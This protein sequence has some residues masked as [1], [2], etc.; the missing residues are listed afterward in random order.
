MHAFLVPL[1]VNI[2]IVINNI[3]KYENFKLGHVFN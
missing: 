1:H 3:I 2:I